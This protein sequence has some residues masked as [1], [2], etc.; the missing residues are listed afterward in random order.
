MNL[1]TQGRAALN[2][3]AQAF[4]QA[5]G[6]SVGTE[7]AL[8]PRV[9][10]TLHDKIIEDGNWFLALVNVIGVPELKGQKLFMGLNSITSTRTD[11]SV[12]DGKRQAR[13]LHELTDME[14]ELFKTDTD[15]AIRYN[16]IDSWKFFKDFAERYRKQYRQAIGNDRVRVGWHGIE[17]ATNTDPATYANGEDVNKGWLQLARDWDG[18]KGEHV[19]SGVVLGADFDNL[20]ALVIDAK[21][22]MIDKPFRNDPGLVALVSD[23]LIGHAE[24]KY[25]SDN[26]ST[27]SEKVHL[28]NG[29]I[30]QT[31]GGL[32]TIVPP[33]FPSGTVVVTSLNNLS[34]Y[35]Q[36]DSWR[37]TLKDHP[38]KDQYEDFNSRNEGYVIE[39]LGAMALVEGITIAQSA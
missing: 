18:T 31:Y 6:V 10:Q 24:G 4:H 2:Q 13:I 5:M 29:R 20:D 25:Y 36:E 3:F 14:F 17:A 12:P 26:G 9:L 8:E 39:E 7:F 33:Y 35:Y 27:P 1:S 15:I 34:I 22:D 32:R 16:T 38:E 28:N 30:L 23:D 19:Q 11:T 37:R 21:N